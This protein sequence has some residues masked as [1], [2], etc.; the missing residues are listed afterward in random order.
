M[1]PAQQ[2]TTSFSSANAKK[3]C[4]ITHVIESAK[5]DRESPFPDSQRTNLA[6]VTPHILA[7]VKK[8]KTDEVYE[9]QND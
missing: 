7:N 9:M 5:R 6:R 8:G 3:N 1:V 4:L 2:L